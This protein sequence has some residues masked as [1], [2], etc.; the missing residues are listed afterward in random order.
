MCILASLTDMY[1]NRGTTVEKE[2]KYRF[3]NQSLL[4]QLKYGTYSELDL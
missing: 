3:I 1:D 2:E 4:L